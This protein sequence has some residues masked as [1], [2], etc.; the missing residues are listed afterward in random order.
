MLVR[1]ILPP[2]KRCSVTESLTEK[3]AQLD[4][5]LGIL[6]EPTEPP[7]T[8]LHLI[9]NNQQEE[10]WQRLLFYYLSPD[11]AHG[12]DYE[13]LEHM[14][15]ALAD[16]D[17]MDYTFSQFDLN[18]ARVE[19]EV[20]T[21]NNRRPDAVIWA[22]NNWFICWE[23][24]IGASESAGQTRDYAE[25]ETFESIDLE[26]NDIPADNHHYI[27]LSPSSGPSPTDRS[28]VPISWEWIA[29][30]LRSF[31][32]D[33]Y[34]KYPAQTTAQI[35]EFANTIERELTMTEYQENQHEKA[36]LYFD[37]YDE[38]GEVKDAFEIE[39][40]N[41]EGNWGRLLAQNLIGGEM[42]EIPDLS[43]SHVA[44]ELENPS[45]EPERW[46]FR[47]NSSWA[48]IAKESWRRRTDTDDYP[49]IYS[50]RDDDN[51][52]HITL[53]HR[54]EKNRELAIKDRTLKLK[55]WHGTSSKDAFYE[56]VDDRV[57]ALLEEQDYELPPN[58]S[59]TGGTGSIL[60]A[61]YD[62][63]ESDNGEFFE[64]YV[65]GLTTA[66]TNLIVDNHQLIRIIDRA[67]DESFS[68]YD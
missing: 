64:A 17:D 63:P 34:G 37:Y 54:L 3:L 65:S 51:Y 20:Q 33:A 61:T 30:E 18:E 52:A 5:E 19:T 11:N 41:F 21:S 38:I 27:Y 60:T 9:R 12:L 56:A 68:V 57:S 1:L 46:I 48:G 36:K 4:H 16:R 62:I 15:S 45:G 47:Q 42:V 32:N 50:G 23:L 13:F 7:P 49:I 66:F 43:D 53:Y 55:L 8:I 10:D 28:F 39:W 22:A 25:A 59:L 26:K 31:L 14:L 2:G 24:K 67:F 29:T 58:I 6:P 44:T 40:E 35:N